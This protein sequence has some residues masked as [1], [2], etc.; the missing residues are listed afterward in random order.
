M[1]RKAKN[2]K[3][4]I[5]LQHI[6]KEGN[7]L[8]SIIHHKMRTITILLTFLLTVAIPTMGAENHATTQMKGDID[9]DGT[10]SIIDVTLLVEIILQNKEV[11]TT[12]DMNGDGE[13]NITDVTMLVNVILEPNNNG[14]HT[15]DEDA[16]P[17][18]PVL[19]P[20]GK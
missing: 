6:S 16:N 9:G 15:Q 10:L 1:P 2:V 19:A 14:P 17:N 20:K 8:P 5:F 12:A 11:S 3:K 18:L 7:T 4:W 13:A